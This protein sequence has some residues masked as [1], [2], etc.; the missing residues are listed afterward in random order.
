MKVNVR[1]VLGGA[2]AALGM[3]FNANSQA[4]AVNA[5]ATGN[6]SA[7]GTWNPAEPVAAD[8]ATIDGS[9]TVT[10]DQAGETAGTL[11]LGT[12]LGETGSVIVNAP[13]DL[14]ATGGGLPSIRVG[15]AAGST[16]NLT[17]NGGTVSVVGP[18]P[19]SGFAIGDLM[20][21]D[22]G[23]GTLTMSGGT[24]TANDEMIIA[25]GAASVGTVNISGGDLRTTTDGRSILVGFGGNGSLN[26]SGTALVTAKLDFL[27]GYLAGATG[28]VNKTG[29]TIEAGL[30]VSNSF[31]GAPGS[32]A[33]MTMTGG[34]FN[35]R[36]AY[37]MGQGQ[38]STT[39]NH[40]GGTIN[41][42]LGNGDFVVSDGTGNTSTYNI[43]GTAAV[44]VKSNV[45][46]GT[47]NGANGTINQS[48]GTITVGN[49]VRL[50]ADGVGAWNLSG[51]AMNG[52]NIF[53]GDFDD[54]YG[55]MKVSGGTLNLTGNLS[56]GGALA[57]NAPAV[58]TGTQGQALD[59]NGTFIVSGAGGDIDIAGNLLANPDDNARFGGL[60][61]HNDGTLIFE[62]LNNSGV[63]R[64]DAAGLADLTGADVDVDLL[65]GTFAPGATF[66][67]ITATSISN[68]YVQVAEDIGVFNLAIVAGGNGQ[69]LRATY[70][71]EP[72]LLALVGFALALAAPGRRGRVRNELNIGA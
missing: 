11:D 55:T 49:N 23:T 47:F 41:A 7:P 54:S 14:T 1:L 33:N 37:V 51:G 39:M 9:L 26:V 69:I 25:T 66:D 48:G 58:P 22:V 35:T 50:G 24:V 53:L 46:V 15:Q 62:I 12:I 4:L 32:T 20:I 64:I 44:N 30:M 59:A 70:V 56:V 6:W 16:G 65:G 60:G 31:S 18:L 45:I 5:I 17:V 10:V 52:K 61:E 36:I 8:L 19:D 38:G 71:P 57:S 43:S 2:I 40:S 21:G 27:I 34:T 68:D 63:S 67:L 72:S 29:V 42:M 28:K 3:L 13:G